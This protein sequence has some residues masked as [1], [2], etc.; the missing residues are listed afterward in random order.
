MRALASV[1]VRLFLV[2][3]IVYGLF[4]ATNVVREHYPAFA[5]IERGDWVCDRYEGM[6][7]DL[8]RHSD[9][10]VYSGNNVMGSLLAVPPLLVLD[11]LLDRLEER[12]K[13]SLAEHPE[14]VDTH[15]ETPH[16]LRRDFY[17]KV[18]LAGLDLRFGAAT[19]ITSVLLMAPLSALVVVWMYA[20]LLRRGVPRPR[21][22]WLALLFAFAT[23]VFYR[24]AHLNHNV[25]LMAAVFGGFLLAWPKPDQPG[26]LPAWRRALAGLAC[27]L[28]VALDYAGIVPA[29]VLAGYFVATRARRAGVASALRE[30]LP[31]VLAALPPIAFLL[32]T[33]WAMYGDPL[34]PGQFVMPR[35]NAFVDVG[36]RGIGWPS[37]EI[38]LKNLLSPSWG[39]LPFAPILAFACLPRSASPA[40]A[41][42]PDELRVLPRRERRWAWALVLSFLT[43]CAM[44]AYSLLQ[45]NTGFRYLMPVVPFLFLLA[46]DHLARLDRRWLAALSVATLTHALVLSM[47][48]E[49]ND[50]ENDVRAVAEQLDLPQTSLPGYWIV[51]GTLT[52]VPASWV[53]VVREGPQLPW[54]SV[55]QRTSRAPS[56]GGPLPAL[57]LLLAA[58]A[59]CLSIWRLGARSE[60]RLRA[61]G[62]G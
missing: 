42:T 45:F 32:G 10:H 24:S 17:R 7:W 18:V 19:A 33:Q 34:T 61:A 15:Y 12:S 62:A 9:G 36:A 6:H 55:L 11:P 23:P 38:F 43:F 40:L 54:L 53:R 44:N 39:L 26:Q 46:A 59:A 48:R 27:G 22:V 5:L 25:F 60:A 57:A 56:L 50:T 31:A 30:S 52:P 14:R 51:V 21:A 49:V 20:T 37:A 2:A 29:A 47:V 1:K 3:W 58:V 8:F 28:A 4:F 35:Q 13:R 41:A 16:P